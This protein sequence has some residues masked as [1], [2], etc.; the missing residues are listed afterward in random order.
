MTR[1][2]GVVWRFPATGFAAATVLGVA[3]GS[4][5]SAG[6][7]P[8]RGPFGAFTWSACFVTTGLGLTLLLLAAA[9]E[10]GRRARPALARRAAAAAGA[11]GLLALAAFTAASQADRIERDPLPSLAVAV[12][13]LAGMQAFAA[14]LTARPGGGRAALKALAAAVVVALAA[15]AAALADGL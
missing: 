13:A 4:P 1:R 9:L 6:D 15:S 3:P 11:F 10:L 12:A 2:T 7:W 5:L 14:R 8:L